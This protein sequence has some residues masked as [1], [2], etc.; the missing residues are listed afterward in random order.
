[1]LARFVTYTYRLL[2]RIQREAGCL[3]E[4]ATSVA[5]AWRWA[6]RD[7]KR[8]SPRYSALVECARLRLVHAKHMCGLKRAEELP[9]QLPPG[10]D[11]ALALRRLRAARR[12]LH[13]ATP[14]GRQLDL[15]VGNHSCQDT[16]GTLRH[17]AE[18]LSALLHQAPV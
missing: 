14:L 1:M 13:W 10:V 16:L 11:R 12:F 5:H 9:A 7:G 18:A 17:D 6:R 2:A 15:Q 8:V 3:E 4:A